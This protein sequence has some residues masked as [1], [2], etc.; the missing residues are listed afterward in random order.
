MLAG[1]LTRPV[2]NVALGLGLP[3]EKLVDLGGRSAE[4]IFET[5][6]EL[7][8]ERSIVMGVGNIGGTGGDLV[9]LFRARSEDK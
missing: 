8:T 5:I 7:T 1:S 9:S 6:V 4:E 3:A 2:R